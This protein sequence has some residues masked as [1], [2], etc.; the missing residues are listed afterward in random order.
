M[1]AWSNHLP[2]R[3]FT[4]VVAC[5]VAG[6]AC[7]SN[8]GGGGPSTSPVGG[9][10]PVADSSPGITAATITLGLDYTKNQGAGNEAIGAGGLF[11]DARDGYN[12]IIKDINAHGGIG[13][14]QVVPIFYGFDATGSIPVD[15]E[16]QQACT[17]WTQDHKVF[18]ILDGSSQILREC[19]KRAGA[20]QFWNGGGSIPETFSEY[21]HYV[22]IGS[23]NMVRM[24]SVTVNGLAKEG[25]FDPGAEVGIV[26]WDDPSYREAVEKG[27]IPALK[28]KGISPAAPPFFVASAQTPQDFG[29]ISAAAKNA[30]L[31]FS[32]AGIDH[33]LLL[34][35]PLGVCGGGCVTLTFLQAAKAQKYTPRYGF[36]DSN[37]IAAGLKAGIFPA[38]QLPGS[39]N[40]GWTDFDISYDSGG[41]VNQ[42]R[43]TCFA[44]MRRAGV[45]MS[46]PNAQ[47]DALGACDDL[48]FLRAV[49]DKMKALGLTPSANHFM[50]AVD[51]LGPYDSPS[52]YGAR[53]GP[54][55]H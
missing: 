34:D 30:V 20:V 15:Q 43:E 5:L 12:A 38:D 37:S 17:E 8:S 41:T 55:Q 21:P 35:G 9:G 46:N 11:G 54:D 47:A 10:R 40:V 19:A 50:S 49:F 28:S 39:I 13:G 27:F 2:I 14:R 7:G 45:D 31:R 26:T 52:L 36:N 6:A 29:A 42:T 23:L 48:W 18:A 22:E 3:S 25:Y 1:R 53:F 24:G 16:E 44:L 33:V 4:L 32:A 51:A